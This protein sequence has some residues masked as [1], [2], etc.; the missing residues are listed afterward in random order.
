MRFDSL[1]RGVDR[2]IAARLSANLFAAHRD[3]DV[4]MGLLAR[5]ASLREGDKTVVLFLCRDLLITYE[6]KDVFIKNLSLYGFATASTLNQHHG[7]TMQ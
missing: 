1:E 6:R 3:D 7:F 4:G 2:P 5:L